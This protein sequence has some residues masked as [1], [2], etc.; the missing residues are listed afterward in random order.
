MEIQKVL[1]LLLQ[2]HEHDCHTE[3]RQSVEGRCQVLQPGSSIA[4]SLTAGEAL[5]KHVFIL[6]VK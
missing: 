4:T 6:E 5:Q 1:F 2:G 3:L